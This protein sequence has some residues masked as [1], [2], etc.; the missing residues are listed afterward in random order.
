MIVA[1]AGP[2]GWFAAPAEAAGR[3][4]ARAGFTLLEILLALG[5]IALIVG[6]TVSVSANLVGNNSATAEDQFWKALN[7]ARKEALT[8]QQDTRLSFDDKAK[9]FVVQNGTGAKTFPV[10]TAGNDKLTVDFL[11]AQATNSNVLIA[12]QLVETQT[13]PGVTLYADGT[14]TPFRLQLR[15]GGAAHIVA[16]DP[17]TCAEVLEENK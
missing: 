14:A 15:R 11:P 7:E 4:R 17:W 5:L 6:A 9:A 10:T 8:S 16:I 2:T 12:G 3:R 1:A 13:L